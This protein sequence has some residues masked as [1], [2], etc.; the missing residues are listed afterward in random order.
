M[1]GLDA[2]VPVVLIAAAL[3]LTLEPTVLGVTVS[4]RQ[5]V[6]AFFGFLGIDT[7]VERTGRLRR[8]ELHLEALAG[9]AAGPPAAGLVLRARSSFERMDAL[10]AQARG[11]VLVVGVNLEGVLGCT[12]ALAALARAGGS[13]RT[14]N[15]CARSSRSLPPTPAPA[16]G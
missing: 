8:I 16:S 13:S 5:I 9:K 14:W 6:L 15:C 2:V 11:S 3:V 10:V 7:L 4:E 12:A 1:L